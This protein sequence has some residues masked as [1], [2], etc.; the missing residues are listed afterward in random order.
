MA[1]EEATADGDFLEALDVMTKGISSVR[2][3]IQGLLQQ[4]GMPILTSQVFNILL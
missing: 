2:E 4:C 3:V 1:V